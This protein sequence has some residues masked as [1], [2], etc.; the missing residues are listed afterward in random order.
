MR[1]AVVVNKF[2]TLSESF[3]FNKVLGLLEAGLDVTVWV[4][5]DKNDAAAF[6]DRLQGH[7][8][9]QVKST[10]LAS[11]T[12]WLPIRLFLMVLQQPSEA[13]H[14][15]RRTRGLYPNLRRA[16][17]AWILAL[18]LASAGFDLIHFELSGL[19]VAYLDALPLLNPAKLLTSC[20]GTGEQVTPI[21]HPERVQQLE[22]VFAQMDAV[23]CVC[24]DIQRIAERYGLGAEQAFVNHPAID[25][26]QFKRQQPYPVS[27]EGPYHILTV[28][29]L[30]WIKGLEFGLLA[31]QRI[32]QAGVDLK[33]QIIGEGEE[34]EKLRYLID[35]LGLSGKVHLSGR[36]PAEKVRHALEEADI[37][38][39]PSLSEGLSNAVLEA[40]AMEIP[41]VSTTAGGMAE[42]ITDGLEGFLVPPMQ[43]DMMAAKLKIL[44][45]Q[46]KLRAQMGQAGRKR[47]VEQFNLHRQINCF[48]EQYGALVDTSQKSSNRSVLKV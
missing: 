43:P 7:P 35:A 31:V 4:H 27:N 46:P 9:M 36:Q 30:N 48:V 42:A 29:R 32:V 37:F 19:A 14:L 12:A 25:P 38:L 17:R 39:L 41:V 16:I 34:E 40:M 11:G 15:W 44:L 23:H 20:R 33:Y 13:L 8:P 45:D 26:Q 22:S 2:P 18:P 10:L 1:L 3:I 21:V 5:S 47:V 24:A 28:G 6:A